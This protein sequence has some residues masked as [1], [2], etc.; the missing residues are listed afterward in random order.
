V[1]KV[2]RMDGVP[3]W[4]ENVGFRVVKVLK[5]PVPQVVV[6]YMVKIFQLILGTLITT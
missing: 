5:A 1:Y 2:S 3:L 6:L 4:L